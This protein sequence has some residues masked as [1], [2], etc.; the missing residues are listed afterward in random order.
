MKT[1]LAICV[2]Y[3]FDYSRCVLG[4]QPVPPVKEQKWEPEFRLVDGPS[5]YRGRVEVYN[6]TS[7]D[8]NSVCGNGFGDTEAVVLCRSLGYGGGKTDTEHTGRLPTVTN[9]T[10]TGKEFSL[11]FCKQELGYCFGEKSA[12][13]YCDPSNIKFRLADGPDEY[14]G[15]VEVFYNE[16]WGTVC[17]ISVGVISADARVVCRSLGYSGGIAGTQIQGSGRIWMKDVRCQGDE[18]SLAYCP[19]KDWAPIGCIHEW[20]MA[21]NCSKPVGCAGCVHMQSCD[22]VT[23]VCGCK[24]GW[25]GPQ[26]SDDID[27]CEYPNIYYCPKDSTCR[28]TEGSYYCEIVKADKKTLVYVAAPLSAII[29]VLTFALVFTNCKRRLSKQ[30]KLYETLISHPSLEEDAPRVEQIENDR[31]INGENDN[32]SHSTSQYGTCSHTDVKRLC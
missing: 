15:R 6:R 8:W 1:T 30:S 10:C 32:S 11:T 14:S 7:G 2:W 16:T 20:D 29:L 9:I 4:I 24:T 12:H 26:C 25:S 3:L 5:L 31:S 23:N 21:V 13:V 22:Q 17:D 18:F 19:F 27:E 28:N